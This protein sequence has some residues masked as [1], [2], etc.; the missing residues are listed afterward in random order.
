MTCRAARA[1]DAPALL[2][3]VRA[4]NSAEGNPTGLIDAT[5]LARD[6]IGGDATMVMVAEADGAL[7]GYATAH[8][9]YETGHAERGVYVG[10][11][12]V[13]P[14]HRR[15][16]VARSLLAALARAGQAQGA[17]HLWL[18]AAGDNHAAHALYRR[19]GGHGERILAFASTGEDFLG[20][21]AEA[22][23]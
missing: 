13:D 5:T 16:G 23:R 4:L 20:L 18:T 19:I 8:P 1:E 2:A 9:T 6:V 15:R 17:R 12:Y 10:D 22:P 21:A 14:A 3:L 11:L 7:I